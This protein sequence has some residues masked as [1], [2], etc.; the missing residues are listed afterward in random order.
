MISSYQNEE[1]F[2]FKLNA[3]WIAGRL[4][5]ISCSYYFDNFIKHSKDDIVYIERYIIV[6]V[7]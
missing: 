6:I 7:N 4:D 5:R 1:Y 2:L 3:S